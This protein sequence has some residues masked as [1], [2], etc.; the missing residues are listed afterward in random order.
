MR[1]ETNLEIIDQYTKKDENARKRKKY[2]NEDK[3][4]K[5]GT[6]LLCLRK[7]ILRHIWSRILF[8]RKP[9]QFFVKEKD[10]HRRAS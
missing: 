6:T 4:S 3:S 5:L 2:P 8:K 9:L 7:S 1:L 10:F